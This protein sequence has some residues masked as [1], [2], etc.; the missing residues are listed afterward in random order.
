M[1]S[2]G[3]CDLQDITMTFG[4]DRS[5]FYEFSKRAVF[6]KNV[7]SFVK[8]IMT[9]CI[10][11]TRC[12]RF[13]N[14]ICETY[15]FGMLSRGV[16]SEI[17]TFVFK[18]LSHELSANVIDLCPVGALTSKPYSF[19]ARPWELNSL[20][21]IDILDSMCSHI[22][23]DYL[24]NKLM[25]IL[26]IYN[27]EVNEDWIS[28]KI[29]FIYDSNIYQR[30][31]YPLI[32]VNNVFINISWINAFNLFFLNLFKYY[33]K[34]VVLGGL[35]DYESIVNIRHFFNLLGSSVFYESSIDNFNS[36]SLHDVYTVLNLENT[37]YLL[38]ISLNLRLEMPILNSKFL[39][40]K[41]KIKF[42]NIGTVGYFYSNYF[43]YLGN[44]SLDVI[45]FVYGKTILNKELY[46]SFSFDMNIFNNSKVKPHGFQILIGQSFYFIKNSF[47]LFSKIKF[48]VQKYFN[49]SS[50]NNLFSNVSVL[51]F[52]NLNHLKKFKR[53]ANMQSSL[54]FLNNVDNYFY[55]KNISKENSFIVYRGSFF[56][57][58]AKYSDLIFPSTTFFEENLNYKS[59][60]GLN[61]YTRKVVS[62]NFYNNKE[63]FFFFNNLKIKFF[64]LNLFSIIN[65]T[66]LCKYFKFLR[67]NFFSVNYFFNKGVN[68]KVINSY[69]FLVEN[70]IFNSLI[71]NYYKTDVYSR[72]SKNISLASLEYL[73]TIITY[74]K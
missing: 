6:D 28:N 65:F 22:R 8:M 31:N 2:G 19:S 52:L 32:K 33:N 66:I 35:S 30:I 14:E 29:R 64:K 74:S 26:P 4:S 7:G 60:D 58:G 47:I 61:L 36:D 12:V 34:Y 1:W 27:K 44:S 68:L 69:K 5:R 37:K 63:F 55:L 23:L 49:Y 13:L 21:S 24:N 50:C 16:N 51:N 45:N 38:M 57:E 10:H 20:E 3:E 71:I 11:C 43:K 70:K 48:Y 9:R 17:S 42:Y 56:D 18:I 72:N 59:F 41:D 15:D 73:K 53:F 39:R 54:Y 67:V 46:N 62:T 40:K 25:R